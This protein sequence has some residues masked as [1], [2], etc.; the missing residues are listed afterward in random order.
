MPLG[1]VTIYMIPVLFRDFAEV[2]LRYPSLYILESINLP[3]IIMDVWISITL[4]K[5][6]KIFTYG[7]YEAN[8]KEITSPSEMTRKWM[9]LSVQG[10]RTKQ[11]LSPFQ[12]ILTIQ[13]CNFWFPFR[14]VFLLVM[15]IRVL[16]LAYG[17]QDIDFW[18]RWMGFSIFFNDVLQFAWSFDLPF[19]YH[20]QGEP[21][22]N[23]ADGEKVISV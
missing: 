11:V 12:G 14:G 21:V 10:R 9:R 8:G 6:F 16:L 3:C 17:N 22:L 18:I 7:V 23:G 2:H 5:W 20:L 15:G 13:T 1:L 19:T 4:M